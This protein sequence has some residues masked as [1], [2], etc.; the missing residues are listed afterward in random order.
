MAMLLATEAVI[1]NRVIEVSVNVEVT[2]L[3]AKMVLILA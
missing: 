3:L 2:Y 1:S